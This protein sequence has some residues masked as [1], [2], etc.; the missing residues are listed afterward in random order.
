MTERPFTPATAAEH[1]RGPAT[2][3]ESDLMRA[4]KCVRQAGGGRVEIK[5]DRTI[6]VFLDPRSAFEPKW[7]E[8]EWEGAKP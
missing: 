3:R 7:S 2:F 6:V 1:R 8:D 4:L 5:P